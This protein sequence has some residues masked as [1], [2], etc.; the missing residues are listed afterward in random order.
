MRVWAGIWASPPTTYTADKAALE[1]QILAGNSY[2]IAGVSVGSEEL[3]RGM[4]ASTLSGYIWDVKGMVQNA[5]GKTSMSVGTSDSIVS[6]K[7]SANQAVLDACDVAMV[8]DYPYYGGASI[9]AA[10]SAFKNDWWSL[11]AM[12]SGRPL[13][14]GETGWPSAG[15]TVG[16]AVASVA[17]AQKYF[18]AVACWLRAGKKPFFFFEAINEPWKTGG[19]AEAQF[20]VSWSNGGPLK[21]SLTC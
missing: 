21:F 20:G 8:T 15:A 4:A 18:R 2:W 14:V 6:L 19:Q 5:Y 3:F 11:G 7:N 13:I 16:G 9:D 10:L 1:Q 17:N 12:M